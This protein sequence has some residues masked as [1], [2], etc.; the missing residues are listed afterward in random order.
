MNIHLAVLYTDSCETVELFY[1]SLYVYVS[2]FILFTLFRRFAVVQRKYSEN[3]FSL[4]LFVVC[5]FSVNF[6]RLV[7]LAKKHYWRL[8]YRV[9]E[10][11]VPRNK[12]L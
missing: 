10:P 5:F 6:P 2:N 3:K 4:N 9:R 12:K 7:I 1:Y 11:K 8:L